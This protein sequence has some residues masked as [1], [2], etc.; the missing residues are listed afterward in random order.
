[1]DKDKRYKHLTN[2]YLN[3]P[4]TPKF[5]SHVAVPYNTQTWSYMN[6][7]KFTDIFSVVGYWALD[8]SS[9]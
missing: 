9:N 1:M 2:I 8:Q 7:Y 6:G 4:L 3:L 5:S